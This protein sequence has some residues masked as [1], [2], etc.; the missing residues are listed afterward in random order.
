MIGRVPRHT[1]LGD[2]VDPDTLSVF[3][4]GALASGFLISIGLLVGDAF[5][6]VR[7]DAGTERRVRHTGA[8]VAD[9][10]RAGAG[11]SRRTGSG[12][13]PRPVYGLVSAISFALVI[14]VVPGASWNFINPE[15]YI[16]D[17][18]WIWAVSLLLVFGFVVLGVQ[19]LRLAPEWLPIIIATI[20]V[21]FALRFALG[22]E[23]VV[24]KNALIVSGLAA[25]AV[26]AAATWRLRRRS[27]VIDVP[28]SVRP[29]LTRSPLA[30][31][32]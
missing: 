20:G 19:T 26:G 3:I 17:I 24:L 9:E 4:P 25:A 2:D 32:R 23:P 1:S 15:G 21:G 16:S 28:P 13:R 27:N 8:A 22:G 14:V 18:A 5:R 6:K 11:A 29:M 7:G 10:V 12:L 31:P 30:R